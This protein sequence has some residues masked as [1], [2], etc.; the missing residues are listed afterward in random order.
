MDVIFTCFNIDSPDSLDNIP[1][2]GRP[3]QRHFCP[4]VPVSRAGTEGLATLLE[5]TKA[6]NRTN[7]DYDR[8]RPLSFPAMGVI[9]LCFN[10]DSP[11][12][13]DNIPES[14]RPELRHIC[15]S[16]P[17]ILA[18]NKNDLRNDPVDVCGVGKDEAEARGT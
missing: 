14:G 5:L 4:S 15:P 6:K 16:V 1:E 7:E 17:V 2:S 13:L 11:D 9:L 10:V 8:L 18:G 3:E 12:S